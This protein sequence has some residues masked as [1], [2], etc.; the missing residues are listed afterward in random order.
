MVIGSNRSGTYS[1]RLINILPYGSVEITTSNLAYISKLWVA[2]KIV[3]IETTPTALNSWCQ[4]NH[5]HGVRK[6][7]FHFFVFFLGLTFSRSEITSQYIF[8]LYINM[9]KLACQQCRYRVISVCRI[10]VIFCV[11]LES[12]QTTLCQNHQCLIT[13]IQLIYIKPN[14]GQILAVNMQTNDLSR[15]HM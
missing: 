15:M 1:V 2:S 3:S 13:V 10:K 9:T 12:V 7:K 14:R 11:F 6:Q 8:G 4:Q 5:R